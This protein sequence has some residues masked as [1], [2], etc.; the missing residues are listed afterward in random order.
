MLLFSRNAA[1]LFNVFLVFLLV[2]VIIVLSVSELLLVWRW[3]FRLYVKWLLQTLIVLLLQLQQC[4]A[5]SQKASEKI[6]QF[7]RDSVKRRYSKTL[8]WRI[9]SFLASFFKTMY[10]CT[11]VVIKYSATTLGCLC[12]GWRSEW[13]CRTFVIKQ[14]AKKEGKWTKQVHLFGI[15]WFFFQFNMYM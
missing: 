7:Y 3:F 1:T 10:T 6:F 13:F 8:W 12:C 11:D 4:I 15:H 14:R 5:V 9:S 2:S